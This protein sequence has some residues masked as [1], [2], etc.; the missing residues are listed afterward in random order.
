M[1]SAPLLFSL[2][3]FQPDMQRQEVVNVGTVLF[4]ESG[5]LLT[6][7]KNP[8]KLLALD[9]N[10]PVGEFYAQGERLR[11]LA[12]HLWCD[13]ANATT[14]VRMLG[15]VGAMTL[16]PAGMIDPGDDSIESLVDELHRDLV[17]PPPARRQRAEPRTSR[18]HAELKRVFR[19][20]GML[21]STKDDIHR[22]LVVPHFP[23]DA[24]VGLFAEFALK[25][26]ALHVTETVDFRANNQSAKRQEAQAKT[27]LLL[28]AGQTIP[29][30]G[31]LRHVVVSGVSQQVQPSLNLLSRHA[32]DV[33]VR[34]SAEDWQRYVDAMYAAASA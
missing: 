28:Q 4:A 5:P 26:G 3:R 30:S 10:L 7:A 27:L 16:S 29:N 15:E 17:T 14:I 8:G 1:K 31:L 34:E 2:V 6:L 23:I 13:G 25:N 33:I 20:A 11:K 21:G 24:E 9:P 18:L 32:E 12:A 19:D 22:H